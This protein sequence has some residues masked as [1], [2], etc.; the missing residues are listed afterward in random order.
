MMLGGCR[1]QRLG[2]LPGARYSGLCIRDG[3]GTTLRSV[4]DLHLV[5]PGEVFPYVLLA[6][7]V[8]R[9]VKRLQPSQGKHFGR[10][11]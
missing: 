6:R 1:L 11:A 4:A 2:I 5:R 3:A 9:D 8:N 10:M 7:D